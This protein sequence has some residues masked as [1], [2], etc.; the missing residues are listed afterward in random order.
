METAMLCGILSRK[1]RDEYF[2]LKVPFAYKDTMFV[3]VGLRRKIADEFSRLAAEQLMLPDKL[4]DVSI[5]K[6][7]GPRYDQFL[8]ALKTLGAKEVDKMTIDLSGITYRS[9]A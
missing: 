9:D 2:A 5:L 3:D 8:T 1:G 4:F 6:P 7:K